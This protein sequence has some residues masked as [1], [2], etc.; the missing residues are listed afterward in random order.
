LASKCDR[1][2]V[3]SVQEFQRIVQ[4][5]EL[6]KNSNFHWAEISALVNV[7]CIEFLY[8]LAKLVDKRAKPKIPSY[9]DT[10]LVRHHIVEQIR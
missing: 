3:A 8:E 1:A 9:L 7:N 4:R 5:K 2:E 10:Q 6:Q